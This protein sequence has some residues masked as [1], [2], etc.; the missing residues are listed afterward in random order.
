MGSDSACL[1][2]CVREQGT[3]AEG[4]GSAV[5]DAQLGGKRPKC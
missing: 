5:P 2:M 1:C 3:G 4:E